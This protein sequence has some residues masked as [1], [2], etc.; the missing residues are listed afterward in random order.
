MARILRADRAGPKVLPA[1]VA[2]AAVHAREIVQRAEALAEQ[3]RADALREARERARAE[4]AAQLLRLAE[5]RDLQLAALE[6]QVIELALR[7][8]R[9]IVGEELALRP[10]RVA[11][12][13]APLLARVRRARQVTLRVHPGDRGMLEQCLQAL[14]THSELQGSLSIEADPALGPGDCVVVSDAGVLD[15]RID[16]QL[17]ALARALGVK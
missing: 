17:H 13:V 16:T 3:S 15:A 8:A 5:Q 4:L 2:E 12:M 10:E 7:A 11:D 14:R 1:I 6:P 9:R